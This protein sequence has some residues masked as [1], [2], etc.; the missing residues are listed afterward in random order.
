MAREGLRIESFQEGYAREA[1]RKHGFCPETCLP[2]DG[3]P[4]EAAAPQSPDIPEERL[5]RAIEGCNAS[6]AGQP[7]VDA[8]CLQCRMEEPSLTTYVSIDDIGVTRQKNGRRPGEERETKY[9]ENT[10]VHVARG[11][12][13]YV[14]AGVSMAGVM[15]LL[16]ASLLSNGLMQGTSDVPRTACCIWTAPL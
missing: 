16:A 14:L 6:G 4:L 9:V 5:H 8:A 13:H 1:L 2:A 11:T 15:R 7:A 10:V 3:A 12:G